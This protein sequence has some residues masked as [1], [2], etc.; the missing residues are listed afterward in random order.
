MRLGCGDVLHSQ[1]EYCHPV[2]IVWLAEGVGFV[3]EVGRRGGGVLLPPEVEAV[4]GE[5]VG[6]VVAGGDLVVGGVLLGRGRGWGCGW[7]RAQRR[8]CC[9]GWPFLCLKYYNA[10]IISRLTSSTRQHWIVNELIGISKDGMS[11]NWMSSYEA[12]G[13]DYPYCM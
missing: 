12:D 1:V 5:G 2:F 7:G 6:V 11:G 10:G 13:I 3:R 8:A 9:A 4:V